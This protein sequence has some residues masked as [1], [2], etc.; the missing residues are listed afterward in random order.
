MATPK[1]IIRAHDCVAETPESITARLDGAKNS[2][3]QIRRTLGMMAVVSM[4]MLIPAYKAY[5]SYDDGHLRPDC[6]DED[7]N[8]TF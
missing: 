6:V 2:Q 8:E 7:D 3:A 5:L 4:M 1:N